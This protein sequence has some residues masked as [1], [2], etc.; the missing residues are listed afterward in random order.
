MKYHIEV[1][2]K[3]RRQKTL[4][5]RLQIDGNKQ[6]VDGE[7]IGNHIEEVIVDDIGTIAEVTATVEGI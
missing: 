1:Y 6:F 5:L 7:E 3:E 2:R 4:L